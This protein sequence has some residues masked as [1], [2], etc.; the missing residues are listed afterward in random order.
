[1][2]DFATFTFPAGI[3]EIDPEVMARYPREY[4]ALAYV[5]DQSGFPVQ[6]TFA[7]QGSDLER[8]ITNSAF[9]WLGEEGRD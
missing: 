4:G 6:R 7:T 9:A 2:Y 3:V 5:L 1:M 8:D